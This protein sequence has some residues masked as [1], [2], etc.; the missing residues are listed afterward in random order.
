[1]PGFGPVLAATFLAN[2]GGNLDAFGSVDRLASV[3]GLAPVLR[4]SGRISGNLHRPR[5]FQPQTPANLLP[6]RSTLQP[7]EQ[8]GLKNL[9]RSEARRRE[10]T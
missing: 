5:P 6:R 1:M 2:I 8:P 4:D 7:E 9:L 10:V 3:A